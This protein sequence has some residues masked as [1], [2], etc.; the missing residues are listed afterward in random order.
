MKIS[1]RLQ[2]VK[3]IFLDSAPVIYY[4]EK[5]PDYLDKTQPIFERLD[6][7]SLS[8]TSSPITLAECLV[9][10]YRLGKL[11]TA[12]AFFQMLVNS[13]SVTFINL[14]DQ[15]ASTA[16]DLRARYNLSLP[17]ALQV[18]AALLAGCDAF[19][20]NDSSLGR[21]SELSMIVLDEVEPG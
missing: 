11:E 16:A 5:N 10:P 12:H 18:A 8:A 9:L 17:D 1:K 7:G 13:E 6:D 20:T 21:I 15:A 14:D 19:L 4:I 3:R 2:S